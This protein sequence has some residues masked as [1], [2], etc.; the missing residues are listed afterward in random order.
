MSASFFSFLG[1]AKN[2][3]LEIA[4]VVVIS[5]LILKLLSVENKSSAG[6]EQLQAVTEENRK[7]IEENRE[8]IKRYEKQILELQQHSMRLQLDLQSQVK[9]K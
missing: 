3:A 6:D 8:R 5:L 9:N 2:I 4:F 1:R 7:L